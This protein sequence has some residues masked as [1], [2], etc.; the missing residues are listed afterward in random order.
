MYSLAQTFH[1]HI[2]SLKY[3]CS[4]NS[5]LTQKPATKPNCR[6]C[7]TKGPI[8]LEHLAVLPHKALVQGHE[9]ARWNSGL[10]IPQWPLGS[11]PWDQPGHRKQSLEGGGK[12]GDRIE[13]KN[14]IKS[15]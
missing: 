9:P 7:I 5:P 4:K 10:M 8:D 12:K 15:I 1:A 2:L 6:F 14:L 11:T 13:T 3:D